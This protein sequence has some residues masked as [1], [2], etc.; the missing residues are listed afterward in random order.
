M[1]NNTKTVKSTLADITKVSTGTTEYEAYGDMGV[2]RREITG[3]LAVR[4]EVNKF[5]WSARVIKPLAIVASSVGFAFM[6]ML[7]T[8]ADILSDTFWVAIGFGVIIGAFFEFISTSFE[9]SL[10]TKKID[11]TTGFKKKFII[12]VKSYAVVMHLITAYNLPTYIINQKANNVEDTNEIKAL[13]AK[14]ERL[15]NDKSTSTDSDPRIVIISGQIERLKTSLETKK[16]EKTSEL[17]ENSTSMFKAKRADALRQIGV[18]D[19]AIERMENKISEAELKQTSIIAQ[20]GTGKQRVE[21]QITSTEKEIADLRTA[22]S[23]SKREEASGTIGLVAVL[24]ILLVLVEVSGTV[25]SVLHDKSILNGVGEEVAMTEEVKSRLYSTKVAF[26]ERN[27]NI[28]AFEVRD[29]IRQNKDAVVMAEY[30]ANIKSENIKLREVATHKQIELENSQLQLEAK[31]NELEIFKHQSTL[32]AIDKKIEQVMLITNTIDMGII[33]KNPTSTKRE[34]VIGFDTH[35][36][37][38]DIV[39]KLYSDGKLKAG[40]KAVSKTQIIDTNN[41]SQDRVYKETT[42]TLLENDVINYKAGF[43]YYLTADYQTALSV[44]DNA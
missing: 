35:A 24:A 19:R 17:L 42:A 25:F 20:G 28:K 37:G 32:K 5:K 2:K 11:R 34:R 31:M 38:V 43:G 23:N 12:F 14:A 13:V 40:D 1:N 4:A 36:T 9:P 16:N 8:E 39:A 10:T 33:N 44:V 41:R 22:N 6:I 15:K 21:N 29:S 3:I 7:M 26:E 30:E 18:I 27:N